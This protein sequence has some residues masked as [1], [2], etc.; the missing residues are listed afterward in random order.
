MLEWWWGCGGWGW[1]RKPDRTAKVSHENSQKCKTTIIVANAGQ[2]Q[3]N[4]LPPKTEG[5]GKSF[6]LCSYGETSKCHTASLATLEQRLEVSMCGLR[7]R[8]VQQGC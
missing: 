5:K 7:A 4:L 2:P 3:V 8:L 6:T 1:T